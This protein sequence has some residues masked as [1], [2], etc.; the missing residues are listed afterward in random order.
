ML[1]IYRED[2]LMFKDHMRK[3][4]VA[5]VT[6]DPFFDRHTGGGKSYSNKKI[7]DFIKTENIKN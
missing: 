4:K 6:N 3:K 7:M 2:R 5:Q 1:M